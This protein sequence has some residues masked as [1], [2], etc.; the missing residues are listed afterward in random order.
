LNHELVERGRYDLV[1][2]G[3]YSPI[4]DPATIPDD[5]WDH[6]VP[7]SG[8]VID[9]RRHLEF[10]ERDLAPYLPEFNPPL[11]GTGSGSEFYLDNGFYG[12]VDAHVLYCMVRHV[13]PARILELGSGFSTLVTLSAGRV[14]EEEARPLDHRIFDPYAGDHI[15]LRATDVASINRVAATDVPASEFQQLAAGDI[16]F[17]DTTHTVRAFGDVNYLLLEILPSLKAGVVV[18][19]HDIFLP[20]EYPELW[21]RHMRRNWG[22]QYLL[23]ALLSDNSRFEVI[24]ASHAVAREH[25]DRLSALIPTFASCDVR[26]TV[27]ASH[28]FTPGAF[29]I[30]RTALP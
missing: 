4:I 5:A 30:R 9:S 15:N 19:V 12:P 8:L 1:E 17:I 29:W 26:P 23:Q 3:Y 2:R 7:V 18:H 14:N 11:V 28:A 21:L 20:W 16:L 24:F 6:P 27:L 25:G 13:K 10:L 22:E